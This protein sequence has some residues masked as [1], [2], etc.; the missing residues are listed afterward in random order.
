MRIEAATK[1]DVWQVALHMRERDFAELSGVN[2]AENREELAH[3]LA[4]RF[5]EHP[6]IMTAFHNDVPVCVGGAI[7]P[8]PGVASLLFFAT[9]GFDKIVFPMTRFIKRTLFPSLRKNGIHRIDA[10]SLDGYALVH[11]WLETIGLRQETQP[12]LG[13]GKNRESYVIFSWVADVRPTGR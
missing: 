6:S 11:S 9:D 13:F 7:S 3:D 2:P 4:M 10:I 8:R 12:L 5:G 1:R